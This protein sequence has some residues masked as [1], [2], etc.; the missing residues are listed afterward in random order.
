MTIKQKQ[1]LLEYLGYYDPENS[2]EV[3]NVDGLWGP[4]SEGATRKFQSDYGLDADGI[5]TIETQERLYEAIA[6]HYVAYTDLKPGAKGDAVLNM[7]L[8]LVQLGYLDAKD[9]NL[10]GVYGNGLKN[11]LSTLQIASGV[12]PRE[13]E[14]LATVE[15]QQFLF[16]ANAD[17]YAIR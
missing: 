17:L 6:P 3:N 2:N 8:R 10:D 13:A 7:Q 12:D 15:V 11:A 9:A 14:G 16:S 5:A 4:A 1:C